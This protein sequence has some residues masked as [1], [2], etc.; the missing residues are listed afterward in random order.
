[1]SETLHLDEDSHTYTLGKLRLPSVSEII[2]PACSFDHVNPDVLERKSEIGRATHKL[3]EWH[4]LKMPI[5]KGSIDDSVKPY[6]EAY[7]KF[8]R[9]MKPKWAMVETMD[10]HRQHGY[11]GTL[12][13]L[14]WI[15]KEPWLID[16]KTVV[17][18]SPATA[19]QTAGYVGIHLSTTPRTIDN[20]LAYPK[21]GALQLKPDGTYRLHEFTDAGDWAVFLS[22]LNW[23]RWR[24]KHGI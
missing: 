3:C 1:M 11:A 15:G 4:D 5:D 14:G 9:E 23:W 2:A 8:C 12:D 20:K 17:T 7:K 6:F 10:H 21:R 18:V 16:L 24:T 22:L 19:L 13:R